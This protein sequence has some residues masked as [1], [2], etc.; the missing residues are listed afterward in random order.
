MS[1]FVGRIIVC[2]KSA[3]ILMYCLFPAS[4]RL[5]EKFGGCFYNAVSKHSEEKNP[6]V[7]EVHFVDR[8]TRMVSS[9]VESLMTKFTCLRIN[10]ASIYVAKGSVTATKADAIVVFQDSNFNFNSKIAKDVSELSGD[11]YNQRLELYKEEIPCIG[12]VYHSKTTGDMA[13]L[14]ASIIHAVV[15]ENSDADTK[16]GLPTIFEMKKI[17]K[18]IFAKCQKLKV[19]TLGVPVFEI[20]GKCMSCPILSILNFYSQNNSLHFIFKTSE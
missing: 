11:R 14:C 2:Y 8:N 7:K 6:S 10:Q 12:S 16:K 15:L 3:L 4:S 1:L 13:T 17:C 5:L 20:D 19:A 18:D 9:V